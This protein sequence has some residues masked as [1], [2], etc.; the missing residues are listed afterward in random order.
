MERHALTGLEGGVGVTPAAVAGMLPRRPAVLLVE[1]DADVRQATAETLRD[2]GFDVTEA[3]DADDAIRI[4][5]VCQDY[6]VLV[7]DVHMPGRTNGYFL[8]RH[9]R[10]RW[11]HLEILMVSGYAVPARRDL[12]VDCDMLCKPY[13]SLELVGHVSALARRAS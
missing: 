9:V 6:E 7:T 3:C 1:D 12:D 4:L 11:P 2:A 5:C 13:G 8:A 10:E